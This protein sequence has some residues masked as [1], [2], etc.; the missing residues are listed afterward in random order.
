MHL[1]ETI[2][3]EFLV[4]YA[5]Q[6]IMTAYYNTNEEEVKKTKQSNKLH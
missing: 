5:K 1:Q 2:Q 6:D 4:T 3:C